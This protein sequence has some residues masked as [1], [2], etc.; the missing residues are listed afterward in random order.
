MKRNIWLAY[1]LAF[2]FNAIFWYGIWVLYYLKFTDYSGIGLIEMVIIITSVAGEIPTGAIAD[3]L[4]KKY[5]LLAAFLLR[6]IGET[7]MGLAGGIIHLISS[8]F[9]ISL[10]YAF[11]SG[12]Y[13]ALIF[14][15]LKQDKNESR[16][17]KVLANVHTIGLITSAGSSILGGLLYHLLPGIPFFA[18]ATLSFLG[19]LGTLFLV[20]PKVDREKFSLSNYFRQTKTGFRQLFQPVLKIKTI[21]LIIIGVFLEILWEILDD[22]LMIEFGFKAQQLGWLYALSFLLAAAAVQTSPWIKKKFGVLKSIDLIGYFFVITLIVSPKLGL[23]LG[24]AVILA[25]SSFSQ[26]LTNIGSDALNQGVESRYRA[27]SLSTYS[28]LTKLPYVLTAVLIGQMM[29]LLTAKVFAVY[30]G[31]A[32]LA[33]ILGVKLINGAKTKRAD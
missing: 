7:V 18:T 11:H 22:T 17:S 16:Y 2:C 24:G 13:E 28:M 25:R 19:M 4:G 5:T 26:V 12:A 3:L 29:D 23:I 8:V 33:A 21:N 6:A 31:L 30:F 14:D 20:E 1:F 32:L 15:S 9:L 27:T 10:G